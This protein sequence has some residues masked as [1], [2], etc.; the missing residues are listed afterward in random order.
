MKETRNIFIEQMQSLNGKK[1][2]IKMYK[3]R[4][5]FKNFEAIK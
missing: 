3:R 1:S 5:L 4:V 2:E